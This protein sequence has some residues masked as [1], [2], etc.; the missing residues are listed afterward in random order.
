MLALQI[1]VQS[2]R[3]SPWERIL[4]KTD[5]RALN[6]FLAGSGGRD[7]GG[8]WPQV[9]LSAVVGKGWQMVSNP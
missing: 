2:L 1:T 8:F 5:N 6:L 4:L 9:P 3:K 7:S